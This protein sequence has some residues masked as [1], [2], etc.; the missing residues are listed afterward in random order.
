MAAVAASLPKRS[1]KNPPPS[2]SSG[3]KSSSTFRGSL[4]GACGFC[5]AGAFGSSNVVDFG[6]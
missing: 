3:A 5:V 6:A 1:P 4:F 2:S